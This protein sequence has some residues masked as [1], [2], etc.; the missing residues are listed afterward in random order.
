[1][2]GRADTVRRQRLVVV[3]VAL[4][5]LAAALTLVVGSPLSPST[6]ADGLVAL[7]VGLTMGLAVRT[8]RLERS[9]AEAGTAR[10][11]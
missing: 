8:D 9:A 2:S 1:V 5:P 4:L 7:A 3:G 6:A 11:T 10:T